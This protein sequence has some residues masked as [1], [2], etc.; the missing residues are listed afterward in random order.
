[1]RQAFTLF[2]LLVVI[3]VIALLAGMLMPAINLVRSAAR[4]AACQNNLR[5]ISASLIGYAGEQE[6]RLPAITL[7]NIG[8]S[9]NGDSRMWYTNLLSDAGFAEIPQW[10]YS[11]A[12]KWGDVRTGIFRCPAWS[13]SLTK[14]G[15][16]FGFLWTNPGGHKFPSSAG[17]PGFPAYTLQLSSARPAQILIADTQCG[18][19]ATLGYAGKSNIGINCPSCSD[20]TT[21]GA[22]PSPRHRGK[23]NQGYLDGHVDLRTSSD[24]Q[25]DLAGW[26]HL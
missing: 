19:S 14:N 18:P 2:E 20:W 23:S 17:I 15:G 24:L 7:D 22:G 1:M 6:G 11:G 13:L 4:G 16:G 9:G 12:D 3:T 5:Q 25:T 10:A 26:G 21:W 8:P